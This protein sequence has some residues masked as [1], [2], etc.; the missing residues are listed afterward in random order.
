[1]WE[2]EGQDLLILGEFAMDSGNKTEAREYLQDAIQSE[3]RVGLVRV[4]EQSYLYLSRMSEEEGKLQEAGDEL[5]QALQISGT[6]GDTIYLPRT[7]T[8]ARNF[9]MLPASR[10]AT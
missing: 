1:M 8:F 2:H 4:V 7:L 5:A 9:R 6:T 10:R 3:N